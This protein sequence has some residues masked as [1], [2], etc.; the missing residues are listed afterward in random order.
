MEGYSAKIAGSSRELTA[1]ERIMMKDTSNAVSLDKHTAAHGTLRICPTAWA[2]V[3]VENPK[4][5]DD[6]Y[7][8]YVILDSE[9]TKYVT[10]S[11]S[12]WNSFIEIWDEMVA[13][14]ETFEIDIY[15]KDSKNYSGKQFLTCSIV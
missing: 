1:R 13:D 11:D 4:S 7:N 14:G 10:G 6:V 3:A 2:I 9:G 15:R 12:L 5:E 8:N